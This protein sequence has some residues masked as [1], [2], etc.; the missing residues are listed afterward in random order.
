MPSSRAWNN[1]MR[2][3]CFSGLEALVKGQATGP[4]LGG[5]RR[6]LLALM[7]GTPYLPDLRG[8]ILFF[9][10]VGERPLPAGSPCVT[11]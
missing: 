7:L 3:C 2:A 9:E 4:L 1:R 5:N 11:H 6:G 10:D 8:A